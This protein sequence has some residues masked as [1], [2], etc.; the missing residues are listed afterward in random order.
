[1]YEGSAAMNITTKPASDPV[2]Q[3]LLVDGYVRWALM[4]TEESVGKRGMAI[5]LRKAGLERLIDHYPASESKVLSRFTFAEYAAL[6]TALIAHFGRASKSWIERIGWATAKLT[7]EHQGTLFSVSS[8][9]AA[10][11][12][13]LTQQVKMTLETMQKGFRDL[14]MSIGQELHLSVEE[15]NDHWAFVMDDCPLCADKTAPSAICWTMTGVIQY[16]LNWQTGKTFVVEETQ[17]R[18]SGAAACVWEIKKLP[19]AGA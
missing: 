16:S 18:A 19:K 8:L 6:N 4:A 1:M 15:H 12:M 3:L 14:S 17:C 5:V 13:P 9:V 11:V 7:I 2:G 10:K